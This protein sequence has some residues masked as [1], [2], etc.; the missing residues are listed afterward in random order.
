MVTQK[1]LEKIREQIRV[2]TDSDAIDEAKPNAAVVL[3]D[4]ATGPATRSAIAAEGALPLLVALLHDGSDWAK[5][6]AA[7][8]LSELAKDEEVATAIV[9]CGAREALA[10]VAERFLQ[11][12][13][14]DASCARN[15]A[16]EA[17]ERL[18]EAPKVETRAEASDGFN[19]TE[20]EAAVKA[21]ESE[22]ST[23][24]EQCKAAE[25]LGNWAATSDV[26][27]AA[28]SRAGGAEALVA[29]V[30][31]GS[32]EAKCLA[33]RAL[34]NLAQNEGAKEHILQADGIATL[35]T[36]VKRGKGKVKEAASQAMPGVAASDSRLSCWE[37]DAICT[38]PDAK[39]G[40][41]P[42]GD[43]FSQIRWRTRGTDTKHAFTIF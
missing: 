22:T 4:L 32:D 2:L 31:T 16:R 27:R 41:N 13:N 12:Y 15:R 7:Y 10:A 1:D 8:A 21:L 5:A 39:W 40:G 25:Q 14:H 35:T 19:L 20:L 9:A 17:L 34:A 42:S 23:S 28:I 3:G 37:S 26:K 24:D 6:Q 36:F 11:D 38:K 18:P 43:V 30:V 33:A 29:L